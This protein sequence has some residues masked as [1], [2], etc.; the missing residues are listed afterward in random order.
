MVK[1]KDKRRDFKP[2]IVDGHAVIFL[3]DN[4]RACTF[5]YCLSAN[6]NFLNLDKVDL[7][8]MLQTQFQAEKL[9]DR[10]PIS[11]LVI[12]SFFVGC[13]RVIRVLL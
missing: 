1:K 4:K 8:M 6:F 9:S 3:A 10:V 5:F 7:S 2:R 13:E 11:P 12:S